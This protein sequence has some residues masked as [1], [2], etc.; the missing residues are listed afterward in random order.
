MHIVVAEKGLSDN[1]ETTIT[2]RIRC[3][4]IIVT[5]IFLF[6][7]HIIKFELFALLTNITLISSTT[8]KIWV[9][10]LWLCLV[11]F[12]G[13]VNG[14]KNPKC[15]IWAEKFDKCLKRGFEPMIFKECKVGQEEKRHDYCI[16]FEKMLKNRNNECNY[17]C[18]YKLECFLLRFLKY[19]SFFKII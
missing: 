1:F 5:R 19:K 6:R 3:H 17:D 7:C 10:S 9:G 4:I 18:K 13:F 14:E 8:M 16:R 11:L 12:A 15:G 2:N